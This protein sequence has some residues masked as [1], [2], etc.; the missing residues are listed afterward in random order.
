[1]VSEVFGSCLFFTISLIKKFLP[2]ALKAPSPCTT[3]FKL[4]MIAPID[5]YD[6]RSNFYII[7]DTLAH[8]SLAMHNVINIIQGNT[9]EVVVDG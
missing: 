5:I 4:S 7:C 6:T 9:L 3:L 1:M 2:V 8:P